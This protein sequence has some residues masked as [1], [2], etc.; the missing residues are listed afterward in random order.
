MIGKP[1]TSGYNS[2]FVCTNI[3]GHIYQRGVDS[4]VCNEI[5]IAQET[6]VFYLSYFLR[7]SIFISFSVFI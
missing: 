3:N 4:I 1:I 6:Q 2:H 5:V 7:P